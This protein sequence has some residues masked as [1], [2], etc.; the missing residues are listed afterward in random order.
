M[1]RLEITDG[2]LRYAG[3]MIRRLRHEHQ[4]A[5][6]RVGLNAHRELRSTMA[7][8]AYCKA[9]FLDG[10]LAGLWGVVG[11]Q[12]A[13]W[14]F[15]WL[16][17]TQAAAR[18]PLLALRTARAEIDK[19]M[20]WKT[21]LT[22]TVLSGDTAALRLCAWLGFHCA[23]EGGGQRAYSRWGRRQLM[24]YVR[25]TPEIRVPAGGSFAMQMGYHEERH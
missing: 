20:E 9:A 11:P 15:V 23:H 4:Q 6:A 2:K 1:P 13:P 8:S 22:T 21:E 14:G 3:P 5:F 25:E 10:E 12:L 19:I 7:Q 18:H 16:A 24:E 17:M